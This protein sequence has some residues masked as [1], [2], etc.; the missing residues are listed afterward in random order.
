MPVGHQEAF[1]ALLLLLLLLGRDR[2]QG[3]MVDGVLGR[4]RGVDPVGGVRGLGR[5]DVDVLKRGE[6]TDEELVGVLLLVAL[7]QGVQF[8]DHIQEGR[9]RDGVLV[10][11][12]RRRGRT[13]VIVARRQSLEQI[14][15]L[16]DD[17]VDK[18]G[19][20]VAV[21][22]GTGRIILVAVR[23]RAVVAALVFLALLAPVVHDMAAQ[24][25]VVHHVVEAVEEPRRE[26]QR[27]E[28]GVQ[29]ARVA[30]VAQG[31]D[32]RVARARG[33]PAPHGRGLAAR[34]GAP[35]EAAGLEDLVVVA[36]HHSR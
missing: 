18:L 29:E 8:A 36:V 31:G 25:E 26:P 15:Q 35:R 5:R 10:R 12:R 20:G 32:R 1:L 17:L 19:L 16:L 30:E 24:A 9:R 13:V 27:V 28:H 11:G 4:G 7:E 22:G 21:G 34:A 6:Q 14:M 33:R 23:V 2:G 3:C